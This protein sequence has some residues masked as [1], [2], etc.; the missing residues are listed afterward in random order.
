MKK[1]FVLSVVLV[2]IFGLILSACAAKEPA[3]TVLTVTGMVEKAYTIDTLIALPQTTTDYTDKDGE[4]TTYS[5]VAFSTLLSDL[6]LSSD[7][8]TVK[9]I[10]ADDYEG[11]VT[12]EELN[13]CSDCII[14]FLDDGTLRSVLP[15]FSG[16]AN[17]K[18][19]VKINL[20]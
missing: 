10:A 20:Q 9:M 16:K 14:A 18:D 12:F 13:A 11:E 7:P 2:L 4:T 5:G 8:T 6:K 3:V 17:V 1:G 19:L 15:N